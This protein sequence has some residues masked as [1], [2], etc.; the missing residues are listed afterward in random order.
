M[1]PL[2]DCWSH[3][4]D[5][6]HYMTTSR[7]PAT[8]QTRVT[9]SPAEYLKVCLCQMSFLPQPFL[10]LGLETSL[11]YVRLRLKT[12]I[13]LK[14]TK[15]ISSNKGWHRLVGT[16]YV[17]PTTS[18]RDLGIYADSD[19][20]MRTHVSRTMSSCFATLCQLR[21]VR[22]STSQAVLLSL[23]VSLVLSCLD[24]GNATLAGLPG[25]QLDR[26]QSVINAAARLVCS[27]RKYEHITP[28]LCDLHLL[29]VPERI[30][31]KLCSRL[32]MSA[33]YGSAIPGERATSC[34]GQERGCD[35]RRRLPLLHHLR[36]VWRL[37]T[38]RS[39]SLRCVS[40]TLCHPAS[41]LLR[42]SAPSSVV[43]K[44]IFLPR[45]S[46]N[47]SKLRTLDF[48]FFFDSEKCS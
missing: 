43:W 41:L 3:L 2:V 23:V 31:F 20:S 7:P 42:H 13:S 5:A 44:R 18:V 6:S 11:E 36:V 16:D 1:R 12:H 8:T 19:V 39:S 48:V 25:N 35:L 24:Y 9:V 26:L 38:V 10:F 45:H 28:L 34:G 46:L 32:L 27:A 22:R 30:E 21:S 4:T 15:I 47:F 33:W 37:V 14:D 17:T 29:R 40:G